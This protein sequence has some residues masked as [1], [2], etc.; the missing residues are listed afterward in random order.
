MASVLD[1]AQYIL[2][3]QGRMTTMKLQKLVYYSQAWS[4]VWDEAPM[5]AEKIQAWANGPVVRKLYDQHT[6][7]FQVTSL[8]RG[9]PDN[10]T[11]TQKETIDAVLE[12]YGNRSAR[13]LSDLT[14]MEE[15]WGMTRK[16]L[17]EGATSE[18][19]IKHE[20]L[21]NYYSSLPPNLTDS[22]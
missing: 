3:K 19:E 9:N 11:T 20:T 7:S 14:H 17:R 15:P 1:V 10:L 12:G 18:R 5:F 8:R 21:Y 4:L 22:E 2:Q 16:G 6:G 13:W